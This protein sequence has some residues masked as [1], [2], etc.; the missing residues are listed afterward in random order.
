MMKKL[1]A[2]TFLAAIAA[3]ASGDKSLKVEVVLTAV[4][5]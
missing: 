4:Q 5:R 1:L 2:A 3:V